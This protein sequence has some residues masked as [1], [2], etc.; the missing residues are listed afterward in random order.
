MRK[1]GRG[2]SRPGLEARL[3]SRPVGD[4]L[5]VDAIRGEEWFKECRRKDGYQK[6]KPTGVERG[7]SNVEGRKRGETERGTR[8]KKRDCGAGI[9]GPTGTWGAC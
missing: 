6:R 5:K 9:Q 2:S 7:I 3:P 8:R 1:H 4:G